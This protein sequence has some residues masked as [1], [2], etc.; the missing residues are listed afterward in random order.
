VSTFFVFL[1]W[2]PFGSQPT[3]QYSLALAIVLLLVIFISSMFQFYQE[4]TT[5]NAM[6]IFGQLLPESTVVVRGGETMTIAADQVLTPTP[7]KT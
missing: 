5:S 7:I 2:K 6:A 3:A 1:S 4:V